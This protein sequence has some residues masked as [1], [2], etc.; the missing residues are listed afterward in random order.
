[1]RKKKKAN[2]AHVWGFKHSN[3]ALVKMK[4]LMTLGGEARRGDL[5]AGPQF[6]GDARSAAHWAFLLTPAGP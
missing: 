6:T 3:R 2:L 1:V 4:V 5:D